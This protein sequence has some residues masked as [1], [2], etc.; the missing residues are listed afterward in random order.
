MSTLSHSHFASIKAGMAKLH[1]RFRF[2][3]KNVINRGG[4]AFMRVMINSKQIDR[5]VKIP[6]RCLERQFATESYLLGYLKR[7]LREN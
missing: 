4:K 7:L 6:E 5:E 1:R 2:E 3:L